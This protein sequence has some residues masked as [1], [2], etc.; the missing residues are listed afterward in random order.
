MYSGRRLRIMHAVCM[1]RVTMLA[2]IWLA[3]LTVGTLIA[4]R[5]S[6]TVSFT[7]RFHPSFLQIL[8]LSLLPLWLSFLAFC[9]SA[10][11]LFIIAFLKAVS[12][13]FSSVLLI[14]FFG[15]AGW[16]IRF[17][18]MFSGVFSVCITWIVWLTHIANQDRRPTLGFVM[19]TLAIAFVSY[20]DAYVIVP[21]VQRLI[22]YL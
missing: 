7:L 9:G 18:M 22:P 16:L 14:C 2:F 8:F 12:F 20:L 15:E 17:L 11:F 19:A 13:G 3:G 1:F 21:I 6:T 5:F 10:A 4:A